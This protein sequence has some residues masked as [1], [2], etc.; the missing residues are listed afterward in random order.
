MHSE[1]GKPELRVFDFDT[2]QTR[3]VAS[4]WWQPSWSR[5]GQRLVF[6]E[7]ETPTFRVVTVNLSDGT[8]ERVTES[9]REWSPRPH[10]SADGQSLYYSAN[11]TGTGTLYRLPL[12]DQ[13]QPEPMTQLSRHLSDALVSPDG[14][15]LAFRR[16]TEIWVAVLGTEPR[17]AWSTRSGLCSVEH[18]ECSHTLPLLVRGEEL[19]LIPTI[20]YWREDPCTIQARGRSRHRCPAAGRGLA[21]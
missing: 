9:G 10:F 3:T 2:G 4:G 17:L 6:G 11:T 16:N 1:H 18:R 5:D 7:Y 13:A 14:K 8:Q 15:W 19:Q 21:G 20:W 12:T